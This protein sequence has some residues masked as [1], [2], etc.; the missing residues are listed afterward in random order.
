MKR[1]PYE[2]RPLPRL[3]ERTTVR[4]TD[5]SNPYD[6]SGQSKK[7]G[8]FGGQVDT[9]VVRAIVRLKREGKI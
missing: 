6:A 2:P 7:L 1:S 3:H 8:W 4:R 9:E 5:C